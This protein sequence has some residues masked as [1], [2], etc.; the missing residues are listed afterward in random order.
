MRVFHIIKSD[1]IK[2]EFKYASLYRDLPRLKF[3]ETLHLA[4]DQ[5]IKVTPKP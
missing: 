3:L 1:L 5:P 2:F 4:R